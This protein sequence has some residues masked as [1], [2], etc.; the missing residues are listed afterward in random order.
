MGRKTRGLVAM[1]RLHLLQQQFSRLTRI[2]KA[3]LI[4][5]LVQATYSLLDAATGFPLPGSGLVRLAFIIITILFM[6]RSF[7]RIVRRLLWRVRHRLL[8]TW[9]LLG[10]VPIVLI[11][12][13][14]AEGLF[15][16][17]GQVV[18]YMTTAEIT[19][20]SELVRSTAQGLAWSLAHRVSSQSVAALAEPFVREISQ[21]RNAEVG[22]IVRTGKEVLTVPADGG[23][24]EIP[25]WSKP[26]FVGLVKDDLRYYL[27]AHVV[28]GD[29]T[30]K[31]EVFLYQHAPADFFKN[32]LPNV[33]TV[34]PVEGTANAAGIDIRRSDERR[35]GVSI[36]T[37][38]DP[39]PV[40]QRPS[41]PAGPRGWW[42]VSV[43][44]PVLMPI[45]DLTTGKSDQSV[46]IVVSRPSL[47]I[48]KL[49]STLGSLASLAVALLVFTAIVLLIVEIV[50][51]LFGAKLTRSITRAV[52]DLYEGTR[53]VQAGDFS[54]RIPI[55]TK[56]QL[57]ELAGSFNAMTE[58]IQHLILEVKEK[59]RLENELAI[60][61]D[62]QS[63]LFPKEFPR[64]KTLELWGGCQPA[65]TVSG[66]YYDF[67]SLGSG[68]AA[69]AIGDVSGKGISAA[70]L[71][72]HIQSALRSQLMHRNGESRAG[73]S[74]GS[75][76]SILSI[77][78]DHLYTSSA[79][80]K[81]AT[82][83]LG[84]YGDEAGQLVY[85]NAGHL[86]P[87]LVRHGQVLR[88]PGEGFPV[89]LFPG[90]QYD[91][92]TV[93]LEPGDLLAG[94]TDGVTETPN[95]D[96]EEFGDLRLTEL[97]VRHAGKPLD[98]IASE[99]TASIATWTGELERHDDTTLVL[100][101]RL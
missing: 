41:P 53:K 45:T 61:R 27:G 68:R 46:A 56:D 23:I 97:L 98:R 44:W 17:M 65:R 80:E 85:T 77:L 94:F 1:S 55:R 67:V 78:N 8:V 39:D 13:L 74:V 64:L 47:I 76:S 16:L 86:A 12:A 99:I 6:V 88:L 89:G 69:L 92:Q 25:E 4:A 95:R 52:A 82:F 19:R 79:P 66:D 33:A 43:G 28:P 20:Q 36:R 58:R 62:V 63:Q 9:V 96:G 5:L 29:S 15:I 91:Q 31:T 93:S 54:H 49:F 60:A 70:L 83:F 38:R 32:L 42:D 100:A 3:F 18:G 71:M 30:E 10:V 87:M 57:S 50:S 101:R 26:G 90:V 48:N 2:D 51:L 37:S 72:A 21:T 35:S 22:A 34:L 84:L 11:C 73:T 59:E 24:R 81:Y 75:P 7:P 40:I 14:V